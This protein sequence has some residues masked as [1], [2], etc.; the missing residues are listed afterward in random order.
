MELLKE[1]L[2][3]GATPIVPVVES[4]GSSSTYFYVCMRGVTSAVRWR[5]TT[6]PE[7]VLPNP[8]LSFISVM[9]CYGTRYSIGGNIR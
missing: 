9:F 1:A 6:G 7:F 2:S 3:E 4:K 8:R 5:G